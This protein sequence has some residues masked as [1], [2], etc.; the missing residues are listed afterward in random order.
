MAS[1]SFDKAK[2][3]WRIQF[4][5][6]DGSRRSVSMKATRARDK[7]QGTEQ[8]SGLQE[9]YRGTQHSDQVRDHSVASGT[10]LGA[11]AADEDT[12]SAGRCWAG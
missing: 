11:E 7:G 6:P 9:P 1:L 5:A 3:R 2:G 12:R 10:Y 8:S 4:L